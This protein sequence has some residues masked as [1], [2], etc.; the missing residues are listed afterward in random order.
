MTDER[1][2][3]IVSIV[4]I[5]EVSG[6]ELMEGYK[7]VTDRHTYHVLIGSEQ[8]CCETSGYLTS[9]DDIQQYIGAELREVRLTDTALNSARVEASDYYEDDGGIQFVYFVT[10]RGVL[11]LA[12]YNA[13]NG[14]YGH[15]VLIA[16]DEDILLND[17]L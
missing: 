15:S 1:I 2:V 9:D 3:S 17:T 13:H 8:F 4:S 11:Q 16:R 12:V 5:E 6:S 7:V 14:Y 10:D